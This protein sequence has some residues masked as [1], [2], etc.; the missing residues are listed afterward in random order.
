MLIQWFPGHMTKAMRK[1]E[2]D[3]RLCDGVVYVLDARAPFACENK[4]LLAIFNGKPIIY[5]INKSDLITKNDG[6]KII[7]VFKKEGKRCIL[8]D[9]LNKRDIDLLKKEMTL[10]VKEK[11]ER[12]KNKGLNRTRRFMIAGIP[13]TGKSTIINTV[14]G[15]KK[16]ETGDKAGITRSNKWI[17]MGDFDLLDTPGTTSPSFEN[18]TYAKHLAYI[19][20]LNDDILD[21]EELA[22]DLLFDVSKIYPSGIIERYKVEVENKTAIEIFDDVCK[23]RGYIF[24]G[25][26][27]DYG[28]GAKAVIDDL[29]KGKLG[30][31]C[32]EVER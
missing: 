30:K 14:S 23:K 4:K 31:I 26:E 18:Q 29:R 20:A 11:D 32:F 21:L 10:A 2:E 27:I 8:T 12:D 6:E 19:G 28:R 25:G 15:Y 7:D 13:N 17:K 16:A 1:T 9:G 24:K 3:I 22:M 5:C